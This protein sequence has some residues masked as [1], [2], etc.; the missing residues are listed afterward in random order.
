M[1]TRLN[2]SSR[3]IGTGAM[4]TGSV[5]AQMSTTLAPGV[6][7]AYG[8]VGAA[9][10]RILL[11]A[12]ILVGMFALGRGP[13]HPVR[14]VLPAGLMF[15][16]SVI[17]M[18]VGIYEAIARIP[19]GTAVTLIII[20]PLAVSLGTS[21][22][23]QDV[24]AVILA[25]VGVVLIVGA[26]GAQSLIGVLWAA[27]AAMSI[28]AYLFVIRRL[29]QR[30][31]GLDG[32]GVG[33]IAA[34]IALLPLSVVATAKTPDISTAVAALALAVGGLV[35]PLVIEAWAVRVLT[36]RVVSLMLTLDPVVAAIGGWLVLGQALGLRS[37]TGIA[38]VVLAAA[39]SLGS[40]VEVAPQ[41]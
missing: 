18:N 11:A 22:R 7:H 21:R 12:L 29:G 5:S 27:I 36:V 4:A 10:V 23:R 17:G 3:L 35:V 13:Q 33:L 38:C 16:A 20:G 30:N 40:V 2:N 8:I 25:A 41:P 39:L 19:L 34:A 32:V 28:A 31:P 9:S 15:G 14:E 1:R 26:H 24:V 37:L 6:F